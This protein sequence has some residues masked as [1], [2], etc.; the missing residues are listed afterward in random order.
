V[1][2]VVYAFQADSAHRCSPVRFVFS[3]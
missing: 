1:V 3:A 2:G